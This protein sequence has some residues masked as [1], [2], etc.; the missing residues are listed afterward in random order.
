[1]SLHP[2]TRL[3]P[4]LVGLAASLVQGCQTLPAAP[5]GTTSTER[6]RAIVLSF[7][8]E[9]LTARHPR[10]AFERFAAK[11]FVDH[12]PEMPVGSRDA[13]ADYLEGLI[14]R[15]PDPQ[16][17][18]IRTVAE[19]NMVVLHVRFKPGPDAAPYAIVDIFRVE[20]DQLVEHWDIVA[21]PPQVQRNPNSRF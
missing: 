5:A 15:F 12:K 4:V 13:A 10:A 1:M 20:N 14:K 2:G 21:E 11:D 3:P 18:V 16:W 7:Y 8:A 9:A 19:G 6:S 17:Q